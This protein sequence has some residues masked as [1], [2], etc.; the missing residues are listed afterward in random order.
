MP[1]SADA[2]VGVRA[3]VEWNPNG[4][5]LLLAILREHPEWVRSKD[6]PFGP[7]HL[8][9]HAV[10]PM[11]VGAGGRLVAADPL[12]F[13]VEQTAACERFGAEWRRRE[14]AKGELADAVARALATVQA[15]A[16]K[17]DG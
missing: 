10:A 2:F 1:M 7:L 15:G 13:P 3:V 17:D 9:Q 4:A 16:G 8:I 6:D 5:R 12:P 11:R 14:V